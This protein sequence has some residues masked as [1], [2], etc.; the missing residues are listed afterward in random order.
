MKTRR[1]LGS[2]QTQVPVKP[3]CP[4]LSGGRSAPPVES[5]VAASCHPIERASSKPGVMFSRNSRQVSGFNNFVESAR[6]CCAIRNVSRAVE[7]NPACP[8][9][10]PRKYA[11]PSCTSPQ[12]KRWR[13]FASVS[14]THLTL[15]TSDLV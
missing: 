7:N 10:P 14:Y 13:E 5:F 15:P 3:L 2:I 12:I 1:W 6:N 11:L 9:A 8:A 4:E